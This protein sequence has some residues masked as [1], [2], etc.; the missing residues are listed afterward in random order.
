[1]LW[2]ARNWVI[3]VSRWWPMRMQRRRQLG[4]YTA[5]CSY[6]TMASCFAGCWALLVLSCTMS[7]QWHFAY[8]SLLCLKIKRCFKQVGGYSTAFCF[9]RHRFFSLLHKF[10]FAEVMNEKR[11]L[12][13]TGG[14]MWGTCFPRELWEDMGKVGSK[15][16]VQSH[17][18]DEGFFFLIG[19]LFIEHG[20]DFMSWDC[21]ETH[22]N[23]ESRLQTYWDWWQTQRWFLT[24][25]WKPLYVQRTLTLCMPTSGPW[26]RMSLLSTCSTYS[27]NF[28]GGNWGS[29]LLYLL[30]Y[31]Y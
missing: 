13:L 22:W 16:S 9:L 29:F 28:I 26:G 3:C 7:H 5:F 18:L 6:E 12:R 25:G 1:M 21:E 8:F 31:V 19:T 15:A 10:Y 24:F 20:R 4:G 30:F 27:K 14:G 11:E 17:L 2:H 23:L